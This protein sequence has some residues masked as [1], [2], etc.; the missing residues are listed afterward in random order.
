MSI[1]ITHCACLDGSLAAPSALTRGPGRWRA[2]A[3]NDP[4]TSIDETLLLGRV[5]Q[6]DREAFS[7]LYDR[8]AGVLYSTVLRILNNPDEACDVLQEAFVQIW[9]KADSYD[10]SLGKPFNWALTLTRNKAIDRLR[11]LKRRYNF[12]EELNQEMEESSLS[13]ST[14]PD[15]VFT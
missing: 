10:P 2:N 13:L 4:Q 6:R 15:E 7:Q 14:G 12:I 5:A 3:V 9:D 11:A 1:A 8:Y